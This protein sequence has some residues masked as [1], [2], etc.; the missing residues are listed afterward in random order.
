MRRSRGGQ[1]AEKRK[2]SRAA[3]AG[4]SPR[5]STA[6]VGNFGCGSDL[7]VRFQL[8]VLGVNARA[9]SIKEA[10]DFVLA[11][12]LDHVEGD[13]SVVVQDARVVGLDKPHS[14]LHNRNRV[15]RLAKS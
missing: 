6:A 3:R 11:R 9:R 2:L 7:H 5:R 13:H 14:A 15:F 8:L 12:G 4:G 10:L 1:P